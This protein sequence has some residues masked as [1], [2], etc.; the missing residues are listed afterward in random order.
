MSIVKCNHCRRQLYY[1][2]D[3]V[4]GFFG[5]CKWCGKLVFVPRAGFRPRKVIKGDLPTVGDDL[6]I[7]G[8]GALLLCTIVLVLSGIWCIVRTLN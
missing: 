2:S 6:K 1:G 8:V 4:Q 3:Y 7:L 5:F